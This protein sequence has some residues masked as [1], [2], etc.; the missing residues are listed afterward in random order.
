MQLFDLER[1]PGETR[2]LS[3]GEPHVVERMLA[4]MLADLATAARPTEDVN[5]PL[6][7]LARQAAAGDKHRRRKLERAWKA[8][9]KAD[10]FW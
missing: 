8:F 3:Q 2:E 5:K 1:D 4:T 7:R 9:R 6:K 10:K